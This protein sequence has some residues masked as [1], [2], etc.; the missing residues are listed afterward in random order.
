MYTSAIVQDEA[1]CMQIMRGMEDAFQSRDEKFFIRVIGEEP[2]LVLRV[3]A[4][5]ILAEI[6]GGEAIPALSDVLLHDPDP[7]VRHEAAF[8][9]GQIGLSRANRALE[10]S[11]MTDMDAIVRHEAAAALGSIGNASA[12]RILKLALKDEAAIVR[13]SAKTSLFNLEFLRKYS[14]G[15]RAR[16]RAPRP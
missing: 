16:E 1:H 14:V 13:N 15:S 4:V 8:S 10:K 2:S 12:E 9:L 3:H 11:V 7:L 5:C 6:G